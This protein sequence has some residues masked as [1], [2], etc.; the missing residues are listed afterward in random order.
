MK[1]GDTVLVEVRVARCYGAGENELPIGSWSFYAS[2]RC[3]EPGTLA[4]LR[5]L[6]AV[7]EAAGAYLK[8][9]AWNKRDAAEDALADALTA[10]DAARGNTKE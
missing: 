7:A 2:S 1:P 6:R 5:A 3:Q 10:L 9:G 8:C 4:E